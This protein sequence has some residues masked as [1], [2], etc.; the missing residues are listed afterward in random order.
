MT[1]LVEVAAL[2]REVSQLAKAEQNRC[3]VFAMRDLEVAA[4]LDQE[5]R[6]EV[7]ERIDL[8]LLLSHNFNAALAWTPETLRGIAPLRVGELGDLEL[9]QLPRTVQEDVKDA[10]VAKVDRILAAITA[11]QDQNIF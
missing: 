5:E 9:E 7:E 10:I 2:L 3:L 4:N 1:P 6:A 8:C 11:F